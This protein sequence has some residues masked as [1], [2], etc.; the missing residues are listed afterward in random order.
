M[1][2]WRLFWSTLRLMG[3]DDE[4]LLAFVR[5]GGR[6]G[7]GRKPP[8]GR[9]AGGGGQQQ[10]QQ[11]RR[12][13][14]G[15]PAAGPGGVPPRGRTDIRYI[16]CNGTG[17]SWRACPHPDLPK[18]KRPCL[19]CKK[20]DTWRQLVPTSQLWSCK[21]SSSLPL[22]VRHSDL[23]RSGSLSPRGVRSDSVAGRLR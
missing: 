10:R 16:N 21:A 1:A 7:G 20:P 13:G 3:M 18:D 17:H 22:L 2:A 8:P 12:A 14:Q 19:P 4:Q 5:N 9:A 11:Q 23:S 15:F 6:L